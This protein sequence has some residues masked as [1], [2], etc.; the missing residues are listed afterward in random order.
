MTALQEK[1]RRYDALI[2][3]RKGCGLC[4]GLAN[5]SQCMNGTFDCAQVGPWSAW[6]GNLNAPV[7]IVG[8]DWGDV[9]WFI[10]QKGKTSDAS[11]TN[12]TLIQ[13]LLSI[14]IKIQLPRNTKDA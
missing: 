13:L 1:R 8:Q 10:R 9:A 7:M 4:S 3:A 11:E 14:G 5:P 6:Q 12:N 2:T